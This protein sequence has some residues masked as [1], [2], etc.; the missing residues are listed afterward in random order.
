MA[1]IN[2]IYD[3]IEFSSNLIFSLSSQN[4]MKAI[5]KPKMFVLGT[6]FV[7]VMMLSVSALNLEDKWATV[8]KETYTSDERIISVTDTATT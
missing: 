7:A 8:Q 6:M 4:T 2:K 1:L 3:K 5:T